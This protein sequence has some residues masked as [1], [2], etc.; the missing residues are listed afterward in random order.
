MIGNPYG[1]F[2]QNTQSNFNNSYG[3]NQG[4]NAYG[5]QMQQPQLIP[6]Q[7]PQQQNIIRV[8]GYE[9]AKAY[10][11]NANSV[12]ALF[13]ANEQKFYLKQ[14]DGGGFST[15]NVYEYLPY[16]QNKVEEHKSQDFVSREEFEQ[17]KSQLIEMTKN[18]GQEDIIS[19]KPTK[20][21]KSSTKVE[22]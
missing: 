2:L 7:Q 21:N 16:E 6:Q 3:Q 4:Y 8:N 14:A 22:V 18:T 12:V 13:D 19:N 9:G 1:Q 17:F 20:T 5:Q 10:T 15:I 11:M